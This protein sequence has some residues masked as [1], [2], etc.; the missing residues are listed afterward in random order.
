M[1]NENRV[2]GA[3]ENCT[4]ARR[5]GR[6]DSIVGHSKERRLFRSFDEFFFQPIAFIDV[7]RVSLL[8]LVEQ[9]LRPTRVVTVAFLF[10]DD[11]ALVGN[12]PLSFGNLPARLHQML[13]YPVSIHGFGNARWRP[14]VPAYPSRPE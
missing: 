9:L 7:H 8:E 3:S 6:V 2:G 4:I 12:M 1:I 11:L 10:R 13:Q 14:A 5:D